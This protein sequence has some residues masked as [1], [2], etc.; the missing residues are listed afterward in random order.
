MTY[1]ISDRLDKYTQ[2]SEYKEHEF[3]FGIYIALT[4][5]AGTIIFIFSNTAI[6]ITPLNMA[7]A[8]FLILLT[9]IYKKKIK[10]HFYF[11]I[12]TVLKKKK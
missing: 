2:T 8:S 9:G 5:L 1:N 7:V 6:W 4:S 3:H 10:E 11:F 12:L